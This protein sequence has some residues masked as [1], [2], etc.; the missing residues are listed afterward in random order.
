MVTSLSLI[1]CA[2]H[3][4]IYLG[5]FHTF[6]NIN[7]ATAYI[8]SHYSISG[9]LKEVYYIFCLAILLT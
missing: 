7:N 3:K 4:V 9:A 8:N 5:V 2:W 6:I 1:A